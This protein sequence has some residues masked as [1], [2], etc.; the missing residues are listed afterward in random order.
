MDDALL[1]AMHV[2]G[3]AVGFRCGWM[4]RGTH[5]RRRAWRRCGSP[6][7]SYPHHN[8]FGRCACA[9]AKGHEGE[10]TCHPPLRSYI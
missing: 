9:L 10:H 5:E 3:L 1:I 2:L 8:V 4:V 7:C 6:M